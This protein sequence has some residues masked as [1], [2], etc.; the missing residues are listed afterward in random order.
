MYAFPG[1]R[2]AGLAP[3]RVVPG[4]LG[5]SP[6]CHAPS[7]RRQAE[8]GGGEARAKQ[9]LRRRG[10]ARGQG[11]P[12]VLQQIR[13]PLLPSLKDAQLLQ[14]AKLHL[15]GRFRLWDRRRMKIPG[16]GTEKPS[17]GSGEGAGPRRAESYPGCC[18]IRLWPLPAPVSCP[19]PAP[20]QRSLG[21]LRSPGPPG[22]SIPDPISL[23]G[24][25]AAS[26]LWP[27]RPATRLRNSRRPGPR[28]SPAP[29]LARFCPRPAH[30]GSGTAQGA[31]ARGLQ[32]N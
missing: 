7:G 1:S 31:E 13:L 32:R 23:F 27:R 30:A 3:V 28:Q 18:C 2:D 22:V 14:E 29:A 11:L 6:P 15:L 10:K 5:G 19:F 4:K 12:D 17:A 24:A 21:S 25:A 9:R 26:P 20:G 16:V 8:A